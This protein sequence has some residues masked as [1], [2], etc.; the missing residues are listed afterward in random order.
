MG[1]EPTLNRIKGKIYLVDLG[2]GNNQYI[3]WFPSEDVIK[4][5]D[6][7][8]NKVILYPHRLNDFLFNDSVSYR[9]GSKYIHVRI[10][11]PRGISEEEILKYLLSKGILVPTPIYSYKVIE[12]EVYLETEYISGVRIGSMIIK[13]NVGKKELSRILN[14]VV[15]ATIEMLDR[16][17]GFTNV[18]VKPLNRYIDILRIRSGQV[19]MMEKPSLAPVSDILKYLYDSFQILLRDSEINIQFTHGDLHLDQFIYNE[20]GVWITDFTGEVYKEPI[21]ERHLYPSLRDLATLLNSLAYVAKVKGLE[22]LH[23]EK[24]MTMRFFRGL[25]LEEN[26]ESYLHLLFWRVERAAYE[27]LYETIMETGLEYIPIHI[28]KEVTSRLRKLT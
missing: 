12:T 7:H 8:T 26:K 11:S 20:D 21:K 14:S 16:L 6:K 4:L 5:S 24:E 28:L 25:G 17:E 27:I 10:C 15:D 23:L 22:T 9:E 13:G 3:M 19:E 18:G 1:F 2:D